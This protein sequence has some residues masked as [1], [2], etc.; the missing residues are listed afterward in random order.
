MKSLGK[1]IQISHYVENIKTKQH[2]ITDINE[3]INKGKI[4]EYL[5][6][7]VQ[8]VQDKAVFKCGHCDHLAETEDNLQMH[9]KSVYEI[10]NWELD[11]LYLKN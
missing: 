6:S 11:A 1:H 2:K 9:K 7:H 3:K 4:L 8:S 5:P 10:R